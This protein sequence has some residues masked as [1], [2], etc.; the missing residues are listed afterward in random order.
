[1]R[2]I[3]RSG[4]AYQALRFA[5]VFAAFFLVSL[6]VFRPWLTHFSTVLI[7]PP[8][9]N[10]QDF[11]NVWYTVRARHFF[12]T[13][14]VRFPEGA[15]LN[16]HSFCYPY[17]FAVAVLSHFIGHDR[18]SLVWLNN[19]SLF[20]S[21]PLAGT[22][23]FYL[24]RRYAPSDAAALPGGYVFAFNPAHLAQLMHHAHVTHIEFLPPFVLAYVSAIER[25]SKAWLIAAA[26]FG[27]LSALCCWYYLFYAV[28]FMI[29][30]TAWRRWHDKQPVAG[31]TTKANL[32]CLAGI[33]V[34]LSPL[35]IPMLRLAGAVDH[36]GGTD[37]FVADIEALVA[38][39]P[40]HLLAAWSASFWARAHAWTDNNSWEGAAY[41]GLANIALMAWLF[42]RR[43]RD[44][45]AAYV[46]WGAAVFYVIAAGDCIHAFGYDTL[47]PLPGLVL[48]N[49]PFTGQVRTPGRAMVIV[50]LFLS[51]GV[52]YAVEALAREWPARWRKAAL[53]ALAAVIVIDFYPAHLAMT[54]ARCPQGLDIIKN[55][56]ELGFGVLN[57][58]FH[59]VGDTAMFQQTCHGRPVVEAAI[60]R[61][62]RPSLSDRLDQHD[63]ATERAQIKAAHVKYLVLDDRIPWEE[64]PSPKKYALR[65]LAMRYLPMLREVPGIAIP[66][67]RPT[68]PKTAYLKAFP[69]VFHSK[70]LTILRVR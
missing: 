63:F 67:Y 41:L 19:A 37:A 53:A 54:D 28:Y 61:T 36:P 35:V 44:P 2:G 25:K 20:I 7:G 24:V 65:R 1:M 48:S 9:D 62:L 49:L 66:P 26:V 3:S 58:P 34:L 70:E 39:P 13:A 5:A 43:R 69:I 55:D 64:D 51:I 30:H 45:V 18:E 59:D 10:M 22:G 23:A 15:L 46:L 38:F 40:T 29:F 6:V 42:R 50:Y 11:W 4:A 8:E 31:W 21:F 32:A 12:E 57:L 27:A 14:L 16:F 56:P 47:V 17:V 52:G 33:F 68:I 60:S